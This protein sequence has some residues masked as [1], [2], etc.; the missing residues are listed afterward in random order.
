MYAV[1]LFEIND[2]L[3]QF[4]LVLMAWGSSIRVPGGIIM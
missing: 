1:F 2:D 4:I 3:V